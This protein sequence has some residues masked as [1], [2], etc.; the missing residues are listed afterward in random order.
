[1]IAN[2]DIDWLSREQEKFQN[3]TQLYRN[4]TLPREKCIVTEENATLTNFHRKITTEK[5][6]DGSIDDGVQQ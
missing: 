6:D 1:M 3:S 4:V 2:K 5:R